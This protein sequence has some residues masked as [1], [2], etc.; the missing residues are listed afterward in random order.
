MKQMPWLPPSAQLHVVA[1]TAFQPPCS[2]RF[3]QQMQAEQLWAAA[4]TLPNNWS[5]G[6]LSRRTR[7]S[8]RYFKTA[9]R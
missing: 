1:L 4:A 6:L 2:K 7:C 8:Q 9:I 3:V 5:W